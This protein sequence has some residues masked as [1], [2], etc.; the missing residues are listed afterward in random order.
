[1]SVHF[2]FFDVDI[3]VGGVFLDGILCVWSP[4]L[5][6]V[7]EIAAML[8]TSRPGN[9]SSALLQLHTAPNCQYKVSAASA[10]PAI[11]LSD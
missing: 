10:S 2:I 1:M 4:S 8:H 7:T 9:T 11:L 3:V 6:S 5:P